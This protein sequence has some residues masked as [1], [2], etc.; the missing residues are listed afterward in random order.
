[1]KL[2]NVFKNITMSEGTLLVIFIIYLIFPVH[3]PHIVAPF[4]ESPLG[5]IAIFC[6]AVY[7]FVYSNPVLAVLFVFVA[8]E[9]LRRGS[10]KLSPSVPHVSYIQYTPDTVE[11]EEE[12]YR[13]NMEMPDP[14]YAPLALQTI[15]EIAPIEPEI[16]I[17]NAFPKMM[18]HQSLEEELVNAMA[19]I[20][21]S[22]PVQFLQTSFLPVMD[23][24]HSASL[25]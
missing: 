13:A 12:M 21:K 7:L 4:V 6:V 1:M 24:A 9:L 19:P 14:I 25:V 15:N 3:T 5:M 10:V 16:P 17:M 8:Y 23:N 22:E 2:S 20:G 11:R 18:E